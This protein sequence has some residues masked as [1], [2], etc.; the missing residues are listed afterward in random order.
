LN[1]VRAEISICLMLVALSG[2]VR[3]QQNLESA[4]RL[5]G[6]AVVA[7]FEA[8]R[9]VL[10]KSSAVIFNGRN[11]VGYG[12]VVSENG[13]VLAKASE[14]AGAAS[15]SVTI[16]TTQYEDAKLVASDSTWDVALLKVE[17]KGLVPVEYAPTSEVAQ[18]TWVVAN[19][20]T[21]RRARRAQPG[22]ISANIREIP[23]AG[24]AA[25]GV[26]LDTQAEG[27][28][29][30]EVNEKGGAMEAGLQKGDQIL[31]VDGTAVIE[32]SEL[33]ELL[34]DR[35][36]GSMVEVTYRRGEE[37]LTARVRLT[38]REE[39]FTDQMSRNDMMSGLFSS[40]R[41]GFPRV[42]Q[43]DILGAESVTGGPL[44]DL[45]GRCI[46]MNI[47]RANRA[48]SFAIP[49]EDLKELAERLMKEAAEEP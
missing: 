11:Q 32:V 26:V 45:D 24:G 38:A 27:I 4:Y 18:G 16:D 23:A 14:L 17:A 35:R 3:G 12:V 1:S 8:Q 46:G 41:S 25:M 28:E 33:V 47:A 21:S 10:Q 20:A 15:L 49:V 34:K 5:T 19:G 31:A 29:I 6:P 22:I 43:H 42:I 37:T 48:E 44:L 39:M 7:A 36:A 13:H 2:P 30:A 9:Q 40:R